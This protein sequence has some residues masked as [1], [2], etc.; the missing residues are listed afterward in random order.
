MRTT[1]DLPDELMR[2]VKIRAAEDGK[3]LKEVM[4]ELL[5][6]GFTASREASSRPVSDRDTR[7][8]Q[9]SADVSSA[10]SAIDSTFPL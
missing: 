1:L 7:Q 6:A 10:S 5:L 2:R 9:R 3:K 4:E 8:P